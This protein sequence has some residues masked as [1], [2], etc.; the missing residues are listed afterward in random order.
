VS[1]QI[2][3]HATADPHSS[4][5]NQSLEVFRSQDYYKPELARTLHLRSSFLR[6]EGKRQEAASD[7]ASAKR[8]YAEHMKHIGQAKWANKDPTAMNFDRMV[9]FWSR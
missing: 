9:T 6:V 2:S 8:L 7:Y 3:V 1:F 4:F 5:I